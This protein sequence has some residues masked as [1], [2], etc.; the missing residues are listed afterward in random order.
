MLTPSGSAAVISCSMPSCANTSGATVDAAPCAQSTST[1]SDGTSIGVP[2]PP[3]AHVGVALAQRPPSA[4][5][6]AHAGARRPGPLVAHERLDAILFLVAELEAVRAEQLDAVVGERIVRG[7]DDGAEARALLA[8]EPGDARRRQHAGAQREAPGGS[9]AGAQR[10][11]E[12]R[13][14]AARVAPD[15][16]R[17][18]VGTALARDTAPRRARARARPPGRGRRRWRRRA[19]RPFRTAG[20][21]REAASASRTAGG[22]VPS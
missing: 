3:A 10:V 9:D 14:R 20:Q 13:A 5:R 4:A 21:P 12:H 17:G 15:D 7:R 22:A 1:R 6:L 11:L 19:R 18:P 16:D 8:H 2:P